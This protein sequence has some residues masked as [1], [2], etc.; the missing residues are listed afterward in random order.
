MCSV[1]DEPAEWFNGTKI[2]DVAV[3][4]AEEGGTSSGKATRALG[5]IWY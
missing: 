2:E 1:L 3:T 4:V 5:G